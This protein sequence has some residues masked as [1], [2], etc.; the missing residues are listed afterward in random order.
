MPATTWPGGVGSRSVA[1][2]ELKALRRRKHL[3][4]KE[5]AALVGVSY[6][7]ITLWEHSTAQPRREHIPKL[8]EALGIDAKQLPAMLRAAAAEKRRRALA[9]LRV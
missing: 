2:D 8:A 3:T 9:E 6:Q 4:Q 5:L 1:V 7:T